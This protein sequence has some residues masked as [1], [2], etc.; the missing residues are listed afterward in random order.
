MIQ[1]VAGF[2]F[3]PE[4][5]ESFPYFFLLY[6]S[7]F[8]FASEDMKALNILFSFIVF[9]EFF[10]LTKK[11]S[12]HDFFNSKVDRRK[13]NARKNKKRRVFFG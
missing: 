13:N 4:C 9:I 5:S 11:K 1:L 7:H 12:F 6:F 2:N 3:L 8:S 10:S